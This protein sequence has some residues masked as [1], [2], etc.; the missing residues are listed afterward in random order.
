MKRPLSVSCLRWI[1]MVLLIAAGILVS[2]QDTPVELHQDVG[3]RF[4]FVAYGD[5]RF[6]ASPDPDVSNAEVRHALV[7]EIARVHPA[8]ISIGGDIVYT[9]DD[10]ADW[11]GFS[12]ETESWRKAHIPVY[13]A[14]GNHEVKVDPQAGLANYFHCFPELKQSRYYSVRIGNVLLLTLDSNLDE[15][16]GV[17]GDWLNR[18]LDHV[19]NGVEFVVIVMH[20]PPLTSATEDKAKGGGSRV[21]SRDEQLARK[22]EHRQKTAHA[23]FVVIA[24]H[25]HNYE[26][27][28]ENGITY[29]VSGGGG[30]HAYPIHREPAD[31]FQ[32]D[33]INYHFLSLDSKPGSLK[34][35]MHRLEFL[36]GKAVWTEPDS[37]LLWR[38]T[39]KLGISARVQ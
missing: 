36:A 13:P 14:I 5:T 29:F 12:R 8:F 19:P 6:T 38:D 26:R 33:A 7:A 1:G 9:G 34:V 30:A 16:S 18:Q 24:G 10:A 35:T 2:A 15:V 20:H 3:R 25:V 27:H 17:E 39:R 31:P 21:R 4:T 32:S 11:Q 28:E 22:L 23:R 37:T